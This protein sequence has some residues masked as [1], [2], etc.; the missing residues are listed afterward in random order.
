MTA[1]P[2]NRARN[3]DDRSIERIVEIMDGW[4][5][6]KLT[7]E[8]LIEQISLRLRVRYTRQ[9]LH[10]HSRIKAAF[11]ERKKTLSRTNFNDP[12]PQTPDQLYI[13][14]L[15]E[16]IE[17]LKRENNNLLEQFNRWIYNGALN[18]L[19]DQM[20]D[21]MN[22]PLPPVYRQRSTLPPKAVKLKK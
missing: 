8:L 19:S 2:R 10:N 17:R 14:R 5:S 1:K 4:N 22:R 7:W 6:P 9:A 21:L 13:S 15:E 11:S 16:E 18:Q 12:K 3:L 20:L